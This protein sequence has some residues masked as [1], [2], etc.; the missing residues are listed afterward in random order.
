[1]AVLLWDAS[2]VLAYLSFPG[3]TF[4]VKAISWISVSAGLY[5]SLFPRPESDFQ[6]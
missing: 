2:G 6:R 4:L 5:P 3:S 1:M